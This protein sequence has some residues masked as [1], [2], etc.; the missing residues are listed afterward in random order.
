MFEQQNF[1]KVNI[2]LVND[3]PKALMAMEAVLLELD[4]NIVKAES[5][6]EALRHL[7]VMEFAVI[8]LDVK[9]PGMDGF[10]TARIIRQRQ[11]TRHI[12]IIFVTAYA[13][14]ELDRST[15]YELGAADYL[16]TPIIPDVLK[17]KVRVFVDLFRT[18]QTVKKQAISLGDVNRKLYEAHQE[19]MVI[20]KELYGIA[21]KLERHIE[22]QSQ[23]FLDVEKQYRRIFEN[24]SEGIFQI[25]PDG[26]IIL[27]NS[28]LIKMLGYDSYEE[29]TANNTNIYTLFVNPNKG[30]EFRQEMESYGKVRSFEV[31]VWTRDKTIIWVLLIA[32]TFH[33]KDSQIYYEGIMVNISE[34]KEL[35]EETLRAEKAEIMAELAA[36]T[37][38]EIRNPLQVIQAGIYLLGKL[39]NKED[40]KINQTIGQMNAALGRSTKFLDDLIDVSRVPVLQ[41]NPID[42]N[43]LL[44]DAVQGINIPPAIRVDWD[45]TESLPNIPADLIRMQEMMH[46]IIKNALESIEGDGVLGIRSEQDEK[47]VK[48]TISDTGKGM[49]EDEM[50]KAWSPFYSNK[51]VGK[52]LGLAIV[53]RLIEA[54][55]GRV[56]IESKIGA[57]TR[58]L[59]RLPIG[60]ETAGKD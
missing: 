45:I 41:I 48:I 8:I 35:E 14:T 17:A 40:G 16:F 19:M 53:K 37:A 57:G 33:K 52:G 60:L 50:A 20:G 24:I 43:K 47:F 36:E 29:F 25:R 1:E 2:L 9:M 23:Q 34:H 22:S 51:P 4:E 58:V 26:G 54:H 27:A 31:N 6:E 42:I 12:P 10:E 5:G 3:D 28:A 7:L 49:S 11:Q 56:D 38:H 15:G 13:Q 44:Q 30:E 46:N 18:T 55:H 21:G 59:V 32:D 39:A